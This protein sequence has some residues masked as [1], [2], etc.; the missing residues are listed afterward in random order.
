MG[1]EG[2]EAQINSWQGSRGRFRDAVLPSRLESTV[3][4]K[5]GAALKREPLNLLRYP[6]ADFKG[7]RRP[8]AQRGNLDVG[9][10]AQFSFIIP[11]PPKACMAVWVAGSQYRIEGRMAGVLDCR[12]DPLQFRG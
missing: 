8:K 2:S 12:Q 9:G 1:L 3:H 11:M 5:K 6:I 4:D 10:R 7:P